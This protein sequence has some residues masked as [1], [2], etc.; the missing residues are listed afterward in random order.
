MSDLKLPS[1]ED[2]I[3]LLNVVQQGCILNSTTVVL[4][5]DST[6]WCVLNTCT[7]AESTPDYMESNT[8][9]ITRSDSQEDIK[10]SARY[11]LDSLDSARTAVDTSFKSSPD[12]L[13]TTGKISDLRALIGV[14]TTCEVHI[15]DFSTS[16]G[17]C[18]SV[19]EADVLLADLKKVITS[20]KRY[21]Q[22]ARRTAKG[23]KK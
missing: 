18:G 14:T 11:L 8:V 20:A 21:A 1:I 3:S 9:K 2:V 12:L 23:T 10:R 4:G 17:F 13:D 5:V 6:G 19:E 22:E 15:E 7:P 16:T